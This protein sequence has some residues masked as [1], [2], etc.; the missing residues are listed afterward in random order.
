MTK[1]SSKKATIAYHH[2]NLRETLIEKGLEILREEGPEGMSLR[3]VARRSGV[4]QAAPY[5]HFQSKEDL[6]A[7]I[8]ELG[9][10]TLKAMLLDAARQH[11]EDALARVRFCGEQY[12]RFAREYSEHFRCMFGDYWRFDPAQSAACEVSLEALGVFVE[13]VIAAQHAGQI[14]TTQNPMHLS[15]FLWSSIHGYASL[16]V[17]NSLFF[18][19]DESL[20]TNELLNDILDRTLRSAQTFNVVTHQ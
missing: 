10:K 2:G 16:Y 13:H 17:R 4:S 1:S 3:E 7:A 9:F 12:F 8:A 6:Y 14:D 11:P 5:R 20:K 15:I 18:I 19:E